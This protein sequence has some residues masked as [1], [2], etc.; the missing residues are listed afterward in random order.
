MID[1]R[2]S[3]RDR[4]ADKDALGVL[5]ILQAG[6]GQTLVDS[7]HRL[8]A[9]EISADG[10]RPAI[11]LPRVVQTRRAPLQRFVEDGRPAIDNNRAEKPLDP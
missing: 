4:L 3:Q 10:T 6:S 9:L 2:Q 8:L 7:L 11:E 1:E 5:S